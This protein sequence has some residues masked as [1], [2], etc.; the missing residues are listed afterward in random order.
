[1]KRLLVVAVMLGIVIMLP[2]LALARDNTP[3][4]AVTDLSVGVGPHTAGVLWTNTGD[5]GLVGTAESFEVRFSTSPIT[6]QNWH[7]ASVFCSDAPGPSGSPGCCNNNIL[8]PGTT[9]YFAIRLKDE[10][11]N[12]SPLS[13]VVQVTTPTSGSETGC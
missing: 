10:A 13:N 3:P 7:Q 11:H 9:Y 5:D 8:S 6:T 4:A 12:I 2:A 1:M